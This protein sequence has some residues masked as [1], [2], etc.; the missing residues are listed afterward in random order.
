MRS[1][2]VS[3]MKTMGI[4]FST[5]MTREGKRKMNNKSRNNLGEALI[6]M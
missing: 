6:P 2:F 3:R 1:A 4:R 5:S